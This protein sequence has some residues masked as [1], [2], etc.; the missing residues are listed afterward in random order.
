[1]TEQFPPPPPSPSYTGTEPGG[2]LERFLARLIDGILIGIVVAIVQLAILANMFSDTTT[3]FG[4]EVKDGYTYAF[5]LLSAIVQTAL[6]FGYYVYFETTK[7]ATLGKMALKLKVVGASGGNPTT[8]ESF[9]RNVWGGL[10]LLGLLG[11]VGQTLGG[12]AELAAVI[13]IAVQIQ[14]NLPS[15]KHFFDDLAGGTQV[16]KAG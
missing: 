13:L 5:Y 9:M 11:A 4:V 2:L 1:M 14:T 7:G 6:W 15:R 10:A 12:L 8:Q 16:V 3:V